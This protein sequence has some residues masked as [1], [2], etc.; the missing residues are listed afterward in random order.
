MGVT[1]S[2]DFHLDAF[3]SRLNWTPYGLLK[4]RL[5]CA[6]SL[7]RYF[8]TLVTICMSRGWLTFATT[9][10]LPRLLRCLKKVKRSGSVRSPE[11]H[12][13]AQVWLKVALS[14][15]FLTTGYSELEAAAAP[16]FQGRCSDGNT[17]R[18]VSQ[19]RTVTVHFG[20]GVTLRLRLG[21]IE[22]G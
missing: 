22:D 4:G 16:R 6:T 8:Q 17:A 20:G 21:N 1:L 13:V 12:S 2:T 10:V 5:S 14:P 19:G 11:E 18:H 3:E 7:L 9:V 15:V